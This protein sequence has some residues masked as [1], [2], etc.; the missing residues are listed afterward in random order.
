MRIQLIYAHPV[1]GSFCSALRDAARSTLQRCGHD[2]HVTDLYAEN[3]QPA[4]SRDER[5]TYEAPDAG[6]DGVRAHMEWI[7]PQPKAALGSSA[8]W[9]GLWQSG[10][11]GQSAAVTA[12]AARLAM[13]PPCGFNPHEVIYVYPM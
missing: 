11:G 10:E 5:L 12:V 13:P 7:D 3:F 8:K 1:E 9:N 4:L 6:I 2:V